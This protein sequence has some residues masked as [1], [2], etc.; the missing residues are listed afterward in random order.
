M[1]TRARVRPAWMLA[2][3]IA[4]ALASHVGAQSH[5]GYDGATSFVVEATGPPGPA[6]G[7]P[8]GPI[9]S[10]FPSPVSFVCPTPAAMGGPPNIFGD[11]AVDKTNDTVWVTDGAIIAEY[12]ASG[13]GLGTPLVAFA[14]LPFG[15]GGLITGLG[16]D[17]VAGILWVTEGTFAQ[18]L[19][20]PPPPGCPGVGAV[21]VPPFLLPIGVAV[22]T[23]IE[24]D[25]VT[26]TLWTCDTTGVVTNVLP[27]GAIGPFGA[28]PAAP[29]PC[30]LAMLLEGLAVDTIG[31]TVFGIP[32]FYVTDGLQV[33]YVLV[34]GGPA[35]PTFYTP[36]PCFPATGPMVGLAFAARALPYGTGADNSGLAPPFIGSTGQTI[37][38]SAPFTVTLAGSVPASNA[39]LFMST[40]GFNCPAVNVGGLPIYIDF[41]T[42]PVQVLGIVPVG[43]G[44]TAS[45]TTGIPPG[46]P[47]GI[48][49]YVQ[50]FA[51]TPTPSWQVSE[52]LAVTTDLP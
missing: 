44:G 27:G 31:S 28:F 9:L 40:A 39:F 15:T 41:L 37:S 45:L 34:G 47:P 1:K 2:V 8:N 14:P 4:F 23:D 13:A 46:F 6:C 36:A 26:A 7:Y 52:G 30:G 19:T 43:P 25:P 18:A 33:A 16:Y 20:P 42:A 22:A 32:T 3:S 10:A 38:P 24:W 50:W 11:V 49:A 17:S 29:G 48:S 35:P 5:Y 12:T 51:I 21:V